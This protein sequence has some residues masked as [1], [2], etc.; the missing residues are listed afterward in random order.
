MIYIES[1]L[2]RNNEIYKIFKK[3]NTIII[4]VSGITHN[5]DGEFRRVFK[6]FDHIIV[7]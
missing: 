6:M 7:I 5:S 2:L 3:L 4:N 1:T